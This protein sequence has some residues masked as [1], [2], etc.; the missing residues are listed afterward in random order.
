MRKNLRKH[1]MDEFANLKDLLV[2]VSKRV[3]A[4]GVVTRDEYAAAGVEI[5]LAFASYVAKNVAFPEKIEEVLT[6]LKSSLPPEL[7]SIEKVVEKHVES[8]LPALKNMPPVDSSKKALSFFLAWCG[9]VVSSVVNPR[10]AVKQVSEVTIQDE[11]VEEVKK[12]TLSTVQY[13]LDPTTPADGVIVK[14][15]GD[16]QEEPPSAEETKAVPV[17]SQQ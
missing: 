17:E 5:G 3:L 8:I 6:M 2:N 9:S 11:K 1:Q 15:E 7:A 16:L 14:K 12:C 10:A 13:I 4:D